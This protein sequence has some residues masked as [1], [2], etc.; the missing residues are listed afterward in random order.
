[1]QFTTHSPEQLF[2][3]ALR[4][5]CQEKLQKPILR[6]KLDSEA[7]SVNVDVCQHGEFV[8]LKVRVSLPGMAPFT[9]SAEHDDAYASIDLTADKL[10]RR[11]RDIEAKRRARRRRT[12]ADNLQALSGETA[13][14]FTEGEED[15]LR[16][17]G[18]L[19]AVLDT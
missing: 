5:Y 18:A 17:M 4:E 15:A 16:Q 13:D 10:E 9:V 1:M 3:D 19:D 12:A 14:V 2:T 8:E 11:V 7:T 6:H